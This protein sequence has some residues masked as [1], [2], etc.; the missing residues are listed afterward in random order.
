M[1]GHNKQLGAWGEERAVQYLISEGY[2]IVRRNFR[3]RKAEVD[4]IASR[5]IKGERT[6]CFVE[7]KT[8]STGEG[9]GER[10]TRVPNKLE[11]MQM[12][13]RA[14]LEQEDI[15]IGDVP[16]QFEHVS[17]YPNGDVLCI[18]YEIPF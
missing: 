3:I 10:A 7:V 12:A 13:A 9:S 16:I 14:F 4:I 17:V 1:E 15:E 6:L 18:R 8:R 2:V 11:K 5:I